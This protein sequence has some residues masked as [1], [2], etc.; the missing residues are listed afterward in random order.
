LGFVAGVN[1]YAYVMNNPLNY[2]DPWGTTPQGVSNSLGSSFPGHDVGSIQPIVGNAYLGL[3][4]TVVNS[5]TA[6]IVYG[7]ISSIPA[8]HPT[9]DDRAD[10]EAYQEIAGVSGQI[11]LAIM[12]PGGKANEAVA[13]AENLAKGG[14][15]VLKNI[16]GAVMRTGRTNDLARRELEHARDPKLEDLR[17]QEA[18]RTDVRS[19]QRGLEQML[20]DQHNPPLNAINPISPS[21]PRLQEYMDAARNF[22]GMN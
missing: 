11:G 18:H 8:L 3:G 20:H 14:T 12:A 5:L 1:Q 17:F 10:M 21:N 7:D 9:P 22:L 4:K 2:N 15:Y 6:G 19:E 16:E 13:V